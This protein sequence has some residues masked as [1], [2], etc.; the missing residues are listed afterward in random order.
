MSEARAILDLSAREFRERITQLA[1]AERLRAWQSDGE[2]AAT[3]VAVVLAIAGDRVT[4]ETTD[5]RVAVELG[6][7]SGALRPVRYRLDA[8][9]LVEAVRD[10]PAASETV[11]LAL[12]PDDCVLLSHDIP[13]VAPFAFRES[14]RAMLHGGARAAE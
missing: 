5:Q 3:D 1:L 14:T 2:A 12:L 10:V 9:R 11:R 7:Q 8:R 6:V 13:T 4:L